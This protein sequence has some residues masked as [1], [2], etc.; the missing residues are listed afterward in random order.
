MW[1]TAA[2][3]ACVVRIVVRIVVYEVHEGNFWVA[4]EKTL[5]SVPKGA[6]GAHFC[7]ESEW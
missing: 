7:H 3:H 5:K 1:V 4:N 6:R 2:T